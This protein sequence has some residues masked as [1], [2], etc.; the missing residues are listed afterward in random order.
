M[1]EVRGPVLSRPA[2]VAGVAVGALT[3]VAG[4]VAVFLT[5][6]ALGST[7]LV[8]AGVVIGALAVFGNH[9]RAIGAGGITLELERAA[10]E[11]RAQARQA[12]AAGDMDRAEELELRAQQL[13][14]SAG[15]V[16]T[17]YELLRTTEPSGWDRTSRLEQVM[18]A[19]RALDA[20][21][22]APQQVTDLFATGSDGN[23][24]VAIALIQSDPRLATADVLVDAIGET[25][26]SF[27]QYQA[28]VAAEQ[29]ADRL[30]DAD[31]ARLRE[32]VEAL[33]AGPLG[34]RSSDRRTVARR[35]LERLS[36]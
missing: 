5:D 13:L 1:S 15:S 25:R 16:A 10:Q 26:S 4:G 24:M 14:G 7:A 32:V 27:E 34:Q 3:L 12:R 17:R 20:E 29:A 6:N 9:L 22:L 28:L 23:R 2:Q 33:L 36:R 11:A 30:P 18:R 35:L 31:R 19:G 8:A 21:V